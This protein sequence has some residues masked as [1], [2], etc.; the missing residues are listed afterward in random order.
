MIDIDYDKLL[1]SIPEGLDQIEVARFL[2]IELGKYF[3]YDPDFVNAT[4][5]ETRRTIANRDIN[6]IKNNRVVCISLSK[7]YIELLR[8]CGI[9]AEIVYIPPDPNDPNDVGHA[10]VR[11][12]IGGKTGSVSLIN[13]LT[14]IKVGLKT[15]HFLPELTEEQIRTAKERGLLDKIVTVLALNDSELRKIDDKIGYT[16]NRSVFR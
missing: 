7:I 15:E 3:I 12:D 5:I 16:Y 11:I 2:Y 13:D 9:K 8:R 10:N 4:D 14:N 1:K 6:E